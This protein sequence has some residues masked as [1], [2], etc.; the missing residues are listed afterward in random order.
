MIHMSYGNMLK[1]IQRQ[2]QRLI[3]QIMFSMRRLTRIFLKK[4][5]TVMQLFLQYAYFK[6]VYSN[7]IAYARKKVIT[8]RDI[9]YR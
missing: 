5:P 3:V 2:N 8:I 6:K 9:V 1:K 4:K 7:T